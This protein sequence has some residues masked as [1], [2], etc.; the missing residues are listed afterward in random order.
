MHIN[1]YDIFHL[2]YC[3]DQPSNVTVNDGS[4]IIW[5][6]CIGAI[7]RVVVTPIND[8]EPVASKNVT[9]ST[10][11]TI[12]NLEP[13]QEY[14]VSVTAIGTLCTTNSATTRFIAQ[15]S[16][17]ATTTSKYSAVYRHAT[18]PILSYYSCKQCY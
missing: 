4:T 5:N 15:T 18:Y 8:S 11:T 13:N 9:L 1:I 3:V 6:G 2:F 12:P 10:T 14:S 17:P 7:Y 16:T